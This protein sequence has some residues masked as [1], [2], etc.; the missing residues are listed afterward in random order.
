[1]HECKGTADLGDIEATFDDD[2]EDYVPEPNAAD[3]DENEKESSESSSEI[4]ESV[5]KRYM[6]AVLSRFEKEASPNF[7][8]KN[9]KE[10]MWLHKFL[11][12]HGYW[13][14]RESP[15]MKWMEHMYGMS[16]FPK[17]PHELQKWERK[18]RRVEK[19]VE[20]AMLKPLNK[21][22]TPEEPKDGRRC[23][24]GRRCWR[25][26]DKSFVVELS[27]GVFARASSTAASSV[28]SADL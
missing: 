21:K 15:K 25:W 11:K 24:H 20:I 7:F 19:A 12:E 9:K 22:H 1:M 13:I 27:Q 5:M 14:Q 10:T 17:H 8:K 2:Y 4:D 3:D 23:R 28:V 18:N 16:I 26:D 6:H